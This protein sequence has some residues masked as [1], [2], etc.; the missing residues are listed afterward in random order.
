MKNP[1]HRAFELLEKLKCKKWVYRIRDLR[2]QIV[3]CKKLFNE[4]YR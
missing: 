4:F 2:Q 3:L 1:Q